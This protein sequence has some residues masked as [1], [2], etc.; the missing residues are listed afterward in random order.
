M[1]KVVTSKQGVKVWK[2]LRFCKYELVCSTFLFFIWRFYSIVFYGTS[3]RAG[4]L[5]EQTLIVINS[6]LL[7]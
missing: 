4:T 6:Y 1:H 2:Y 5:I 7:T 3:R